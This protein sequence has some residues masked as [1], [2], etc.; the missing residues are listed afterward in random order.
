MNSSSL[1][2]QTTDEFRSS[3]LERMI[4]GGSMTNSYKILWLR[5]VFEEVLAGNT[6]ISFARVVAR[7]CAAAWYPVCYF[8]LSFGVQDMMTQSV[9]L[10]RAKTG[11]RADAD[12]AIVVSTVENSADP[13]ILKLVKERCVYVPH[14]LIRPFY[15]D[16]LQ[17]QKATKGKEL[18]SG[19]IKRVI[20]AA[21]A[22]D[23][24]GAPYVINAAYDGLSVDPEW[25]KYF[26][27][28]RFVIQGWL[29][30]RL[31]QY[32]QSRNPCVPA[33]P[34]KI[35]PPQARDLGAATKYWKEALSKRSMR[36]IYSG[37]EFGAESFAQHGPLSIDHF[38]PWSFVLHD[39]PWNLAPMFRDFNSSKG[40]RL[41][42]LEKHLK[43]FAGQQFDALMAVRETGR[44]K[45]LLEAYLPV[46]A[47]IYAYEDTEECRAFFRANIEN[48]IKPLWQIARNQGFGLWQPSYEYAVVEL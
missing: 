29:D 36:E 41:P 40:D 14:L 1:A 11:L 33:I 27:E 23:A 34:M 8:R 2:F 17:R 47:E 15:D 25:A 35:Y 46:D 42:D 32:L 37:I 7:M 24:N 12:A 43:S 28:N 44:H 4:S 31:V 20:L 26:R 48:A 21:N 39:E 3:R 6:D 5:G 9:D 38:V 22:A 30:M 10:V 45:K 13:A 19:E 16:E 18:F